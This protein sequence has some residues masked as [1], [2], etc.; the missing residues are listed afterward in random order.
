MVRHHAL[1]FNKGGE[2]MSSLF[3]KAEAEAPGAVRDPAAPPDGRHDFDFFAG[4][5]RVSH[6]RLRRRLAADTRW[7]EFD[8]ACE[9]RPIIGGLGNVDD[10]LLHLPASTYRA[11]TLRL[12]DPATGDWSIWWV[13]GRT[14]QLEPPVR[15]RFENGTGTFFGDDTIDGRPIRVRFVWSDITVSSAR[16][17]QA[18]SAD[19]GASWETNWTMDFLRA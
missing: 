5:W 13:D 16:W 8:G 3:A 9:S 6:R 2:T 15:G 1:S 18:F 11:A 14:M 7:E 17:A 12:F 19:G 10:N 4:T